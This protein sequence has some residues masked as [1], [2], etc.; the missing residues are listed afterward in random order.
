MGASASVIEKSPGK[1]LLRKSSSMK[2]SMKPKS[3]PRLG[4]RLSAFPL[5]VNACGGLEKLEGLT[6]GKV[7]EKF[8]QPMTAARKCSFTE[9]LRSTQST[10]VTNPTVYVIHAWTDRFL[11]VYRAL[12]EHYRGKTDVVVWMDLFCQNHHERR[13]WDFH[14]WVH[15]LQHGI[16]QIGHAV[17]VMTTWDKPVV[18]SR[19]WCLYEAYLALKSSSGSSAKTGSLDILLPCDQQEIFFQHIHTPIVATRLT[20]VDIEQAKCE[21]VKDR[22]SLLIALRQTIGLTVVNETVQ[23]HLRQWLITVLSNRLDSISCEEDSRYAICYVLA[24]LYSLD[25]DGLT[26]AKAYYMEAMYYWKE[27]LGLSHPNTLSAL[28][29]MGK[30][31]FRECAYDRA[32][33]FYL[34]VLQRYQ[35][36]LG[37]NHL[38]TIHASSNLALLYEKQGKFAQAEELYRQC[39]TR[40]R[41]LE[42]D[43]GLHTIEAVGNQARILML[44][45]HYREA[46]PLYVLVIERLTD[47]LGSCHP[48][49]LA[50]RYGLATVYQNSQRMAQAEPLFL[51]I[52]QR[53]REKYGLQ[54]GQTLMVMT[55]LA[56]VQQGLGK[57]EDAEKLFGEAVKG[58]QK[59][60]GVEHHDSLYAMIGWAALL[61][62]RGCDGEAEKMLLQC[63]SVKKLDNKDIANDVNKAKHT[64]AGL[65]YHQK[66]Y[67]EA[68]LLY[69]EAITHKELVLGANSLEVCQGKIN[70]ACLYCQVDRLEEAKDIFEDCLQTYCEILGHSHPTTLETLQNLAVLLINIGQVKK[71]LSVLEDHVSYCVKEFGEDHAHSLRAKEMLAKFQSYQPSPSN[72]AELQVSQITPFQSYGGRLADDEGD[73]SLL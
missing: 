52:L 68:E 37:E 10:A 41:E 73:D 14:W 70:L 61:C 13:E 56:L 4:V 7:W 30:I 6:T 45:G 42:G 47:Q 28:Y 55:Q 63:V 29:A 35:E 3:F 1:T 12:E 33:P 69:R 23:S 72:R 51:E 66:R 64:L 58:W 18:L 2:A 50:V 62:E 54:H 48:Q 71:G 21:D 59:L 20:S 5:F 44:Q 27:N 67:E 34:E 43:E 16:R 24:E 19:A 11:D 65:Y 39:T 15:T 40:Y 8:I 17:L 9:L 22:I 38:S 32:E 36:A 25:Q 46:E 53:Y 49:T 31:Y 57:W 26:S 60:Y